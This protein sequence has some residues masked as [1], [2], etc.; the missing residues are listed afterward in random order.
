[1]RYDALGPA[2]L[3]VKGTTLQGYDE[4]TSVSKTI[5]KPDEVLPRLLKGGKLVLRKLMSEINSKESVPNG[6]INGDTI[7]LRVI[8]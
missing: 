1:M 7:L 3:S 8:K 6:R 5:R 4:E 2:G